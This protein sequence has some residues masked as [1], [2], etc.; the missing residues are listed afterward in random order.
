MGRG[1]TLANR[2]YLYL[3]GVCGSPSSTLCKDKII[4]GHTLLFIWHHVGDLWDSKG[5]S[6]DLEQFFGWK[7]EEEGLESGTLLFAVDKRKTRNGIAFRNKVLS[8]QKLEVF[9][10]FSPLVGDK[11]SIVDDLL[12]LVDF[13]G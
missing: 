4:M 13:I 10:C 12:I 11:L 5:Y 7:E 6:L 3:E 8:I 2:C 9:F 1:F